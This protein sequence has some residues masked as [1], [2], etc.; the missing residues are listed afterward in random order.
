M[1]LINQFLTY[2]GTEA[3]ER[4]INVV[5]AILSVIGVVLLWFFGV[6]GKLRSKFEPKEPTEVVP[7]HL[8]ARL[9]EETKKRHRAEIKI[10]ALEQSLAKAKQPSNNE[11]KPDE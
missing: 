3:G 4:A 5:L 10:L 11:G 1:D 9:I 8:Y 7:N 6:L 2:A